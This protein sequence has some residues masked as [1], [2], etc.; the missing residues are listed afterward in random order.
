MKQYLVMPKVQIIGILSIFFLVVASLLGWG[1]SLYLFALCVGSCLLF[2]ILITYV[3]R[4]KFFTKPFAA[5]VTGLILTLI[6][7]P[8]ATWYQILIITASAM[9]IKNFLRIKNRHVL[10][11]AASG[12]L[13]GYL[14][15]GLNP[16]W[17]GATLHPGSDFSP[18]NLLLYLLLLAFAYVSCYK[19]GRY[20][21]VL[22][23]ILVYSILFFFIT[24]G[25][26]P[27]EY[28][29]TLFSPGM[30]FFAFLMLPEPMTS[31]VNKNRQAIYGTIVALINA[32]LLY[33]NFNLGLVNIPDS[34]IIALLIGNMLFFKFR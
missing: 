23:Y 6:I 33:L 9:A 29:R 12:L 8:S 34:S 30:L 5:L 16:S 2:D 21:S 18:I 7:D 14:L 31:P 10:N 24:S 1:L 26:S 3:R 19:V 27:A 22:S 11:P 13:V 15:F 32:V 25:S 17:W 20:V 28:F 4:K